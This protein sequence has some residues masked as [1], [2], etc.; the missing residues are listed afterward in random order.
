[1][2]QP[3]IAYIDL[4]A[5][6]HNLRIIKNNLPNSK[7]VAM[8]KRDAYGHGLV[9]IAQSLEPDVD[10]FGTVFLQ[11]ALSLYNAGIKKPIIVL[12]GFL[13]VEELIA[14][15]EHGFDCSIH[16]FSQITILENTKLSK[17]LHVWL[18]IDTGLHRLGFQSSQIQE[19]YQRL[20]KID[21]VQKPLKLMTHFAN[22]DNLDSDKTT[23]QINCF[24]TIIKD[25]NLEGEWCTSNSAAILG[26]PST[27]TSWARPGITLYGVSPFGDKTGFDLGLKPVMTLTSKIIATHELEQGESIGYGGIYTCPEKMRIGVIAIGYGDGYPRNTKTGAPILVNGVRTQLIGRVAMDMICVDLRPVPNTKIGDNVV[28]WGK[29]LPAEEVAVFA[30]ESVYELLSRLTSRVYYI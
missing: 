9:K 30:G 3:T 6:H 23:Q 25:L 24:K 28:L 1:M 13:D 19:A 27:H 17:P 14:I 18:E 20:M 12:S 2:N 7:I 26:W 10:A 8:V 15:D 4:D 16:N 22:A 29:G 21:L 11:E 5:L